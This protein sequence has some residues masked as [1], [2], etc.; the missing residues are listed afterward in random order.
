MWLQIY[1]SPVEVNLLV[2]VG[3]TCSGYVSLAV[4]QDLILHTSLNC[5]CESRPRALW[6]SYHLLL[7]SALFHLFMTLCWESFASF[8][9]II[10]PSDS[11]GLMYNN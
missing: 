3:V 7:N 8:G 9:L 4:D 1:F 5:L 2:S 10:Y 11:I 6:G